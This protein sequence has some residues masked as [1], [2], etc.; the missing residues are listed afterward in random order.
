MTN[1]SLLSAKKVVQEAVEGA[2]AELVELSHAIAGRPETGFEEHF[3]AARL[4][5]VLAA[6]GMDVETGVYELDTALRATTGDGPLVVGLCAE[7]DALPGIGHA[8]GHNVIAASSVGAAIGLG[9]VAD[10]LGLTVVL[11]GTPAE[12]GGGGKIFMLERGAFDGIHFAM[13]VHPWPADRLGAACLAVSHLDVT[14]EGK[15]AH[16]AA[17]PYEG[18]NAADAMVISQVALGLL[19]QHFRPGNQ[20]HGVVLEAGRAANVI[21]S[22]AKGYF[23][24]RATTLSDLEE[25]E[26]RV[27]HCFEA[28]AA[29]TGATLSIESS[30]P[31]YTHMEQDSELLG[32]YRANAETLGRSFEPDDR[33]DPQPFVSTDMANVSLEVPTIH[34]LIGIQSDGAV[35]HQPEFAAA[36]VTPSADHATVDGAVALAWTGVDATADAVRTRLLDQARS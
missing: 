19:R 36:C 35:N 23:M 11:L 16:A 15:D 20:A 31:T 1:E 4:G 26:P 25:L 9:K 5:E 8:C 22:L 34:P 30:S 28:G 2:T 24:C 21:P 6:H 12:E 33:G 10:D 3:A 29:A 27:K 13:M 7:Y 18:V 14:F 17:S 32:L